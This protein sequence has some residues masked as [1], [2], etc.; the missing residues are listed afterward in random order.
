[1]N[2]AQLAENAIERLGER[3]ALVFNG[4]EYISYISTGGGAMLHY[5]AK[6]KMSG[7][8]PLLVK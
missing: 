8:E 7:L 6:E 2:L 3:K 5:L 1:M 4:K